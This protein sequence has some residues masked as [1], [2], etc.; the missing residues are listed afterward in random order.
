VLSRSEAYIG[1]LIDDLV[2]LGTREP[3]RMF[4]SR[5]EHRISLRHDSSDMR[6]LERG[7]NIGLQPEIAFARLQEKQRGLAQ[8]VENLKSRR[9]A[10]ANVRD[11]SATLGRHVGKTLYQALKSPEVN[12][13]QL[14][15]LDATLAEGVPIQWLRQAELDVKYEGYVARQERQIARI[16]KME[17]T[18]IPSDFDYDAVRGISTESRE[19]LKRIRPMSLGQASRVPGVRNSDVVVLMVALQRGKAG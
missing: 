5:A 13:D 4:T 14:V 18:T 11:G 16:R 15:A 2:T 10:E 9:I 1:V 17:K 7:H 3:Y 12:L 19:Q 8:L 6:L